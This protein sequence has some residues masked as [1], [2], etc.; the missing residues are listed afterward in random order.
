MP[1]NL[2]SALPS[3]FESLESYLRELVSLIL[4]QALWPARNIDEEMAFDTIVEHAASFR[5]SEK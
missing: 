2:Q 4:E 3:H 5:A 1:T